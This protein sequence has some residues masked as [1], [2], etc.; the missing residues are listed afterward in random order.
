[1]D[2]IL[3]IDAAWTT[4]Q[5]SGV[6]LL[7]RT[8]NGWEC[9][10]VAPSYETFLERADGCLLDWSLS[11]QGGTPVPD[12]LLKA[13][14]RMVGSGNTAVVVADLPLSLTPIRGRRSADDGVSKRFGGRGCAVHSPSADRP[15]RISEIFREGFADLGF[16]LAVRGKEANRGKWLVETYPHPALLRL[17]NSSYRVP[18]K[19]TKTTRYWPGDSKEVRIRKLLTEHERILN[20]LEQEIRAVDLPLPRADHVRAL[21]H[22]KRFEDAIDSLVCAWVGIRFLEREIESFGDEKA[23]IWIPEG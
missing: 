22:L 20:R 2:F 10:A 12:D 8:A 23:A 7:A 19:V 15:G 1:M 9:V 21:N 11:V 6:A 14:Q 3:G 5:P 18:Y 4:G 16:R 13:A 17:L